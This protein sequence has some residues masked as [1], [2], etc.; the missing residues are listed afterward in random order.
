MDG[1]AL[2]LGHLNLGPIIYGL[3]IAAGMLLV[4]GKLFSGHWISAAIDIA[5]FIL[6]FKMHGGSVSGNMAA[7]IAAPI[8]S[9]G[10]PLLTLLLFRR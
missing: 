3:L 1:L 9:L 7:V 5:V 6:I 2:A 8:V 4:I 10:V